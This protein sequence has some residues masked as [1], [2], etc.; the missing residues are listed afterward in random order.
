MDQETLNT[1]AVIVF[2]AVILLIAGGLI[3]VSVFKPSPSETRFTYNNFEFI[4]KMDVWTS[5]WQNKGQLYELSFRF[6]PKDVEDIDIIGDLN[7]SL[8]NQKEIFISFDPN[9]DENYK[10]VAL[11]SGELGLNLKRAM[12]RDPIF[13]CTTQNTSSEGCAKQPAVSCDTPDR[14]VILLDPK[15]NTKVVFNNSCIILGG[16][17][18]ELVRSVDKMLYVW[19]GIMQR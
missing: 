10:Y 11:A 15:S 12:N 4:K 5:L 19:Y 3:A 18:L 6:S 16:E 8:F 1:I 14:P 13:A 17:D 9:L 2:G 7:L